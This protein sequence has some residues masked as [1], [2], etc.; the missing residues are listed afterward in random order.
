MLKYRL[1][2]TVNGPF[3]DIYESLIDAENALKDES[4]AGQSLNDAHAQEY[5]EAGEPV[6]NASDFFSIVEI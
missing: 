3:G 1:A 4:A 5:A 6:P 2:D